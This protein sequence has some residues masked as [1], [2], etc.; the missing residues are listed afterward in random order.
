MAA[1]NSP[2]HMRDLDLLLGK[3]SK[4]LIGEHGMEVLLIF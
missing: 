1:T 3:F 4:R 2:E